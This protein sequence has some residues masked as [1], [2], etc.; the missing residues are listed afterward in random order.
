VNFVG[1]ENWQI[2]VAETGRDCLARP[3]AALPGMK[4]D[5]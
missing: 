3:S 2:N 5:R 4:R 1:L